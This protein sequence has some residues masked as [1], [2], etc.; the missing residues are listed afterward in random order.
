MV[1]A[2]TTIG[3][4]D[5]GPVELCC[6]P[7]S[8]FIGATSL[9]G[10]AKLMM[11]FVLSLVRKR[12]HSCALLRVNINK[13]DHRLVSGHEYEFL[14]KAY[15][16][17]LSVE[18]EQ[19]IINWWF[20]DNRIVTTFVKLTTTDSWDR[21]QCS[22]LGMEFPAILNFELSKDSSHCLINKIVTG[23]WI[24]EWNDAKC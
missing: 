3:R 20:P 12:T 14:A 16:L 9:D 6:I 17:E 7:R 18:Y 24:T 13:Y 4:F 15:E 19:L 10:Y 23:F 11:I 8:W 2:D 1:E 21:V 22:A 5:P